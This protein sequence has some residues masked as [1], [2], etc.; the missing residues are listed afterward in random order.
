MNDDSQILKLWFPTK[1]ALNLLRTRNQHRRIARTTRRRAGFDFP[2]GYFPRGLNHF[3]HAITIAATAEIVDSAALVESAEREYVRVRQI[4]NV[5][6]ITHA[7]TVAGWIVI[8][9]NLHVFA[10]AG[11]GLEYERNQMRFR[12]VH[13]TAALSRTRRIEITQTRI[14]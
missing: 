11:G 8:A 3:A 4:D 5:D 1:L 14:T 10:Y 2:A 13:F 7:G 6:V 9:K 12:I